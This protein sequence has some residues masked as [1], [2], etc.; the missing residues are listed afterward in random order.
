MH[1]ARN[2][3]VVPN[4]TSPGSSRAASLM[5]S[6]VEGEDDFGTP[7]LTEGVL[8]AGLN[9]IA[10]MLSEQ[11]RSIQI[12]TVGGAVNTILLRTRQ[13]TSDV[14][15]FYHTHNRDTDVEN[16]VWAAESVA[17]G[18]KEFDEQCGSIITLPHL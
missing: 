2:L 6:S 12:V 10:E 3:I 18:V 15:F 7:Q 17:S 14:D 1:L 5:F 9:S 4:D 11:G 8:R 16:L 13:A